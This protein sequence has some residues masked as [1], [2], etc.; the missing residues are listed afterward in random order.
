MAGA[1]AM[2]H[3]MAALL[4]ASVKH[5]SNCRTAMAVGSAVIA[6]PVHRIAVIT[7]EIRISRAPTRPS[8]WAAKK[9][10][11]SLATPTTHNSDISRW[12]GLGRPVQRRIGIQEAV[13]GL[14][15]RG[16]GD[17]Q[18]QRAVAQHGAHGRDARR[19]G[20]GVRRRPRGGQPAAWPGR[21]RSSAWAATSP[22][23]RRGLDEITAADRHQG[24]ASEPQARM[25]CRNCPGRARWRSPCGPAAAREDGVQQQRDGEQPDRRGGQR[26]AGVEQQRA[27][28]RRRDQRVRAAG[29]VGDVG[30]GRVDR[31]LGSS[32]VA[33]IRPMKALSR[34]RSANH[35]GRKGC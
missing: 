5:C 4:P 30:D 32:A 3:M 26:I 6:S 19:R 35:K 25:R 10:S 20:R 18:Q 15:Q 16:G 27:D 21:P 31:I 24:E 12:T 17:A 22:S 8:T 2:C 29:L 1:R 33:T 23:S 11:T 7:A 9:N 34:P 13:A 28:Q 14:H